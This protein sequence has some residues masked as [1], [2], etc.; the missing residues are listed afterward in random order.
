MNKNE[1]TAFNEMMQGIAGMYDK[2]L[3]STTIAIYF[4][5]LGR[6]DYKTVEQGLFDHLETGKFMPKP[7]D[8]IEAIETRRNNDGRPTADEA[9]TI[10]IQLQD[11]AA[12]VVSNEEISQAWQE[13]S[14]VM[15]DRV[16]ARMAFRSAYE[17]IVSEARAQ[18][19]PLKW[20]PSLG[21]DKDA[22]EAPVLRSIEQGRLPHTSMKLIAANPPQNNNLIGFDKKESAVNVSDILKQLRTKVKS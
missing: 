22:R 21:T 6:F 19:S 18:N 14:Y 11:E 9:F 20:F 16:G 3:N 2:Q 5:K 12:T 4:K 13:A 1:L 8:I 7:A 17:R 10:A 15:P